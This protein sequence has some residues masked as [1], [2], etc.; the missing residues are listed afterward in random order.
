MAFLDAWRHDCQ[1]NPPTPPPL[2]YHYTDIG[3]LM[4]IAEKQELWASNVVYLNDQS[5]LLYSLS[6]LKA[7]IVEESEAGQSSPEADT[8]IQRVVHGF[9]TLQAVY[10]VCFCTSGDLLSQWRG[11]GTQGGYAVGL[12]SERLKALCS[13]RVSLVRVEY[14]E[15]THRQR[16][17]DL[18]RRWRETFRDVPEINQDPRPWNLAAMLLAEAFSE[19]AVGFK[20]PVFEEEKEWR[21]VYRRFEM[22]PDDSLSVAFRYR[23][24]MTLP[25][26]PLPL[27]DPDDDS[28][29]LDEVVIGPT[30]YPNLAGYG[31]E[32]FLRALSPDYRNVQVSHSTVPLRPY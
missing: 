31:V 30:R 3:A 2:L 17:V 14:D 6:L 20:N 8:V 7:I 24:G 18:V 11:Y 1:A 19:I 25:Y 13:G 28:R 15:R 9:A 27:G 16:L 23:N 5:E 10:V 29:A 32:Q 22:I 4:S 26:V 21:L 12:T